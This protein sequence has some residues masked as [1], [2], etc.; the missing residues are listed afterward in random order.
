M[1]TNTPELFVKINELNYTF[2]AG[3]YDDSHNFKV[4]DKKISISK[5]IKKKNLQTS[6]RRVKQ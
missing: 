2:V 1:Q 5:G 6:M 4:I 3:M